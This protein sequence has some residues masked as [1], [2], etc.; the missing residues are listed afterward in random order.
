MNPE[1]MPDF[2]ARPEKKKDLGA[3][4]YVSLQ[5]KD[6]IS[7]ED[8][9]QAACLRDIQ[10]K[11]SKDNQ[12]LAYIREE[13]ILGEE[14]GNNER[15]E[16]EDEINDPRVKAWKGIKSKQKA[17]M[18]IGKDIVRASSF[19]GYL[20]ADGKYLV[21]F[22]SSLW[23]DVKKYKHHQDANER[24][25]FIATL[26][27]NRTEVGELINLSKSKIDNIFQ[28]YNEREPILK[29]S[30]GEIS[31][32]FPGLPKTRDILRERIEA[33]PD[34]ISKPLEYW[35]EV[36]DSS[37]RIADDLDSAIKEMTQ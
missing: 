17:D 25:E 11:L 3:L 36:Y 22:F 12:P 35:R 7:K 4:K 18:Y 32:H 15:L 33:M 34:F 14:G 2:S 29:V 13:D 20:G 10:E 24:A 6:A 8:Y 19:A 9:E 26:Y 37:R 27:N 1:K 16:A 30:V 21:H 5:M 23:N 31:G 28:T